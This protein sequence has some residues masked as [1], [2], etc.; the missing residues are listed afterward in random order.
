MREIAIIGAGQAGVQLA[1]GLQKQ[2]LTVHLYSDRTAEAIRNG[3]VLSSQGV[4][5]TALKYERELGLNFWDNSCPPNTC[6]H[7]SIADLVKKI[8]FIHWEGH[9]QYFYQSIDQRLKIP[10]WMDFFEK[11][12]GKI[13]IQSID[14]EALDTIIPSHDLTLIATGKGEMGQL[15]ERDD[16]KSTFLQPARKLIFHHLEGVEPY[17]YRGV[18]ANLIPNVG[19]YFIMPGLSLSGPCEM[20]FFEAIPGGPFDCWEDINDANSIF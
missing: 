19:E 5:H 15:F 20:M 13:I 11:L 8:P 14:E 6:I 9:T 17:P 16:E 7:F 18:S 10:A 2:G 1:I 3:R 4:F 12:G